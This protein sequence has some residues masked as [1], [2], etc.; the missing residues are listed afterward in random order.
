MLARLYKDRKPSV[1][2]KYAIQAS[3][4]GDQKAVVLHAEILDSG[5]VH[6]PEH[7]STERAQLISQ[8]LVKLDP[9]F[10]SNAVDSES[11][12]RSGF[13]QFIEGLINNS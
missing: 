8:L 10:S 4:L 3:K 1:A 2:L 12:Q 5:L 13:I 6:D 7:I 9:V 11:I